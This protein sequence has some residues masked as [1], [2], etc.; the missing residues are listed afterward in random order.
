MERQYRRL[1]ANQRILE[2]PA[3]R[4][5]PDEIAVRT[6]R[7]CRT[8]PPLWTAPEHGNS[9]RYSAP[10]SRSQSRQLER[11]LPDAR[12]RERRP[13]EHQFLN[14]WPSSP[15]SLFRSDNGDETASIAALQTL[16]SG[17]LQAGVLK[18]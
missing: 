13:E 17:E 11:Y 6:S 9:E 18:Q 12:S 10:N 4:D 16:K 2:L 5:V 14:L 1:R 3:R 8:P 7:S 15:P